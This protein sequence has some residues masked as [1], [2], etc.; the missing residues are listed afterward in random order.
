MKK[1][2]T[3]QA[4]AEDTEDARFSTAA[5]GLP[6]SATH[7]PRATI[8]NGNSCARSLNER[9]LDLGIGAIDAPTDARIDKGVIDFV[10][11]KAGVIHG[12]APV[13]GFPF[14]LE[15]LSERIERLHGIRF[16]PREELMVTPG[17]IKGALTVVFHTFLNPGDEVLLPTPNWPHYKD[18]LEL[19]RVA[20]RPIFSSEGWHTGLTTSDLEAHITSDTRMLILGDCVNP[21]GKVYSTDELRALAVVVAKHNV[22][23][24]SNGEPGI[25]VV[26]DCPYETY[27]HG[28]RQRHFAMIDVTLPSG[29]YSMRECT[30]SLSGPGK[31]YG[32]HGDRLGYVCAQAHVIRVATRVQVNTNSF[33]S[34]YAQAAGYFA[35]G[36]AMDK[37]ADERARATRRAVEETAARLDG[38]GGVQVRVPDGGY[39]LFADFTD[40]AERYLQRG[41]DCAATFLL[42]QAKVATIDGRAFSREEGMEHFARVNCGRGPD[43]LDEACGRIER[44]VEALTM[45]EA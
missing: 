17:G 7:A 22:G 43:V 30:V 11:R 37:T 33:A 36:R 14:V 28:D 24:R 26:F 31:T 20:V 38:L 34:T 42:R 3:G 21:T 23:R 40:C 13:R 10:R 32:M 25:T 5:L 29:H 1:G 8:G 45:R 2:T 35:F 18:M 44:A 9:V 27:V 12:F 39:F 6:E 19:H 41:C 16:D 4:T 15:A